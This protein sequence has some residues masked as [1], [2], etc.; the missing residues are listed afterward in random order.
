MDV[1]LPTEARFPSNPRQR[2]EYSEEESL[3]TLKI[4]PETTPQTPRRLRGFRS[5]SGSTA[6]LGIYS[7]ADDACLV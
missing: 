1:L 4:S 6:V 2:F 3:P 5:R 7:I